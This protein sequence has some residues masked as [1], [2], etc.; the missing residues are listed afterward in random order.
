MDVHFT[1]GFA[2]I[3]ANGLCFRNWGILGHGV[4]LPVCKHF[5]L[6]C[7]FAEGIRRT[8]LSE[9]SLERFKR[10][11]SCQGTN[12]CNRGN[13][14]TPFSVSCSPFPSWAKS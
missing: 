13:N 11:K 12:I 6:R 5:L 3:L 7:C 9:E 14:K 8:G 4:I 1:Y 2:Q 10:T